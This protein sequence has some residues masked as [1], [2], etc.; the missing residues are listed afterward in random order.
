MAQKT[1]PDDPLG[2]SPL[3]VPIR[4]L[5]I[6][7]PIQPPT[8]PKLKVKRVLTLP[9]ISMAHRDILVCQILEEPKPA[10]FE[11][12]PSVEKP[13]LLVRIL[14]LDTMTQAL[15]ICSALVISA[16]E[17]AGGLLTGR[18]F[19]LKSGEIRNGKMFNY[20]DIQ[21]SEMEIDNG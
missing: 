7:H 21:T 3:D 1:R 8:R 15:L 14:D 19:A 5:P 16:F 20:R 12:G 6:G 17:R 9:L 11:L 4:S 13:P 18:Y 10:D 2:V